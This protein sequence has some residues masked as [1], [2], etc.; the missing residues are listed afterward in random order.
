VETVS[1]VDVVGVAP[2]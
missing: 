1:N 2:A